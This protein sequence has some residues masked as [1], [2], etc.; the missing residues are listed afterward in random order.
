MQRAVK[1]QNTD[2]FWVMTIR[3]P[4]TRYTLSFLQRLRRLRLPLRMR[5]RPP[6]SQMP[7]HQP[8]FSTLND[9]RYRVFHKLQG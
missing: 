6:N 1:E 7:L 3:N 9:L 5:L 2:F 4:N 8:L